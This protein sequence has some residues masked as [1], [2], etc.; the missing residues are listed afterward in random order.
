MTRVL[1]LG[2]MAGTRGVSRGRRSCRVKRSALESLNEQEERELG[3]GSR[4]YERWLAQEWGCRKIFEL[5]TRDRP[6][7][8]YGGTV[9]RERYRYEAMLQS[10][11][12]MTGR[13]G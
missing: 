10:E 11:T 7:R 12:G 8:A 1:G 9:G 4:S 2:V 6:R 13:T 3:S 5:S